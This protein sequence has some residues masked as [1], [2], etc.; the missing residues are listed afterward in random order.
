MGEALALLKTMV[1][2]D[3]SRELLRF[4]QDEADKSRKHELEMTKLLISATTAPTQ[5]LE[6]R[7]DINSWQPY[8]MNVPNFQHHPPPFPSQP[9]SPRVLVKLKHT[10]MLI[11][12]FLVITAEVTT[13]CK[14]C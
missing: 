8:H 14:N 9:M 7:N 5:Q 4:M 3:P 6:G 10:Q 12:V 11:I 1:E 2:N 13:H